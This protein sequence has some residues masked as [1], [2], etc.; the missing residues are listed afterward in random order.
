MKRVYDRR[1]NIIAHVTKTLKSYHNG[2]STYELVKIKRVNWFKVPSN[3]AIVEVK[4]HPLGLCAEQYPV[5][6]MW[7]DDSEVEK[8]MKMN[9]DELMK[10]LAKVELAIG[11][12][13]VDEVTRVPLP[14]P[15]KK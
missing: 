14:S 15:Y 4:P 6:A 13:E 11:N 7:I 5:I 10:E 12:N 2:E 8:F 1:L 9:C 3:Y